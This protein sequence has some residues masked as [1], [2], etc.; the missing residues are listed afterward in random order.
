MLT[1]I[2]AA[3]SAVGLGAKLLSLAQQPLLSEQRIAVFRVLALL[4]EKM[5]K[6]LHTTTPSV[7]PYVINRH[8]DTEKDAVQWR[9]AMAQAFV[10]HG[11]PAALELLGAEQYDWLLR[12]LRAGVH[13]GDATNAKADVAKQTGE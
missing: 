13:G 7:L 2:A 4:I 10:A 9:Y 8:L 6:W 1:G 5:P 12:F 11:H 3:P